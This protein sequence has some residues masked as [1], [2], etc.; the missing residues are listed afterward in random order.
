MKAKKGRQ[1][2]VDYVDIVD[3]F[4]GGVTNYSEIARRVGLTKQRVHTIIKQHLSPSAIKALKPTRKSTKY[5]FSNPTL[6]EVVKAKQEVDAGLRWTV[7]FTECLVCG[8]TEVRH[9]GLGM[10]TRCYQAWR[11]NGRKTKTESTEV[12]VSREQVESTL[13]SK[14]SKDPHPL[15]G[16]KPKRPWGA[17]RAFHP[18]VEQLLY[19]LY[20]R[21]KHIE[22][23]GYRTFKVNG[24]VVRIGRRTRFN[25][26]G[27][28]G[29]HFQDCDSRNTDYK[30]ILMDGEV[31]VIPAYRTALLPYALHEF[32]N[33]FDLL[34]TK[35]AQQK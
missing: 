17:K 11:L 28:L 13:Q 3:L 4:T 33:R 5:D 29:L 18:D 30:I 21:F 20:N 31:F 34:E 35:S 24:H 32:R 6:A 14:P 19:Y 9:A 15:V 23:L 12:L 25:T 2:S 22:H 1:P 8:T 7:H 10:C 27:Q 26:R 16:R